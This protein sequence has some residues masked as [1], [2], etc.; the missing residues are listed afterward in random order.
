MMSAP[1]TH[2]RLANSSPPHV[3]AELFAAIAKV[4]EAEERIAKNN[5][6]I[7]ILY[8][9]TFAAQRAVEAAEAA[10]EK[11]RQDQLESLATD[12]HE[13]G[14]DPARGAAAARRGRRGSSSLLKNPSP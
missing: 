9:K 7:E 8:E 6:R 3:R 5:E 10:I 14:D 4:R 1:K 13:P 2:L 12:S 11:A